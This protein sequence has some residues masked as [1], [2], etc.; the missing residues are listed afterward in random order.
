[1]LEL[2][3]SKT[4]ILDEEIISY[5]NSNET[6]KYIDFSIYDIS[7][8]A[9]DLKSLIKANPSKCRHIA[10]D[11]S[12]EVFSITSTNIPFSLNDDSNADGISISITAKPGFYKWK[13]KTL[14]GI[15]INPKDTQDLM[16]IAQQYVNFLFHPYI[17]TCRFTSYYHLGNVN[18]DIKNTQ[19]Y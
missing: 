13:I 8:F 12:L 1:M 19:F 2:A 3:I 15:V 11:E 7:Q 6:L 18:I 16:S 5:N 14:F 9:Y 4:L 10:C 17:K